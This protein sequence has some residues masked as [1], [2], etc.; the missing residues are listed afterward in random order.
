MRWFILTAV[1]HL[2]SC[3]WLFVTP[4]TAAYQASLSFTSVLTRVFSNSCPSCRW[5]HPTI[6]S[7][8]IPSSSCL[9][10][11]PASGSFPMSL[12]FPSGG[13]SIGASASAS[14]L[15]MISQGCFRLGLTGWI[16][17]QSRDAQDSSLTPKFESISSSVLSLLYDPTLTSIHSYWKKHDLD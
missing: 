6:S 1:V 11:I 16:S 14:V 4:W 13:Q 7:P 8:V 9:L 3:V 15:P 2:L 12:L 5:C 10:F 17:L